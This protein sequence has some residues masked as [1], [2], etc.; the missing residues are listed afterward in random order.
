[1][2]IGICG[3]GATGSS[4]VVHLLKEYEELQVFDKAE[5]QYAFQVD[6]LQ[7]LE[8]HLLKRYSRHM[9][10]DIA[11]KRFLNVISWAKTPLVRKTIE[12]DEF[13]KITNEYV[14]SLIQTS[15]IGIDN[16]DYQG[17]SVLKNMIV[18]GFKKIIFPY[19]ESIFKRPWNIW[20]ARKIYLSIEPED[21]YKKTRIYTSKLLKSLGADLSK[22]IVLDQVFEGNA[23]QNSFPFFDNAKAIVIDRDPRDLWLVAKYAPDARGEAR[24]MPRNN[25]KTYVE[26]YRKLRKYQERK[27]SEEILFLNFEELIYEYD[28]TVKKIENFLGISKHVN[29]KKYFKPDISI[30]NTQLMHR[31]PESKEE[32]EYIERE[33]KEYLF[34]FSKYPK[35]KF[36]GTLF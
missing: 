5:F 24:F 28:S 16:F 10:G 2:I 7:D 13:I 15:W 23:P 33:L 36:S 14:E 8:Y 6:G 22:P 9:S 19:F 29:L 30:N 20:P 32:V 34:D 1:M 4:A 35:V 12:K 26:Y 27:D 25:V 3:Y 21:F 17:K 11:I 18:L 31:Y